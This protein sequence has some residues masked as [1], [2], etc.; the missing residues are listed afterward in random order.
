MPKPESVA[1]VSP[2]CVSMIVTVFA[3]LLPTHT[4][5]PPGV[6]AMPSSCGAAVNW[7]TVR[8]ASRSNSVMLP[9]PMLAVH[10]RL[11]SRRTATM[12]DPR[13]FVA[14]AVSTLPLAKSTITRRCDC[15]L[16]TT[17]FAPS[18]MNAAPC[19][20]LYSPR[21]MVRVTTGVGARRS[22]TARVLP[23]EVRSP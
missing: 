19:G 8:R 12:C 15:S 1:I 3:E 20:R 6:V 10:A 13:A 2:F 21:S 14:S 18:R 17:S 4:R 9:S 11:P 16:V 23:M 7:R 5:M 22:M